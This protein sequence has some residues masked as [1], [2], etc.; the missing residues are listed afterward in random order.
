MKTSYLACDLGAESGR[1]ML[2]S[3]EDGRLALEELHRF[4]NT[5]LKSGGSLHWDIPQLFAE[6]KV[7]L[8]K[9][10]QRNLPISSIS[11][12]SW[13][14]D[15]MLFAGDGALI[16][17]TFHYRDSRTTQGAANT[18]AKVDWNTIFA[19]TGIQFMALNTLY[20]LGAQSPERLR[21]AR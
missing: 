5:P 11:T 14:V 9:A 21:R 1:L 12:D 15:Y 3:L 19:E 7:G 17:P 13:G 20:Q 10:A 18:L 6:L 2:G 4:P 8:S 16:A